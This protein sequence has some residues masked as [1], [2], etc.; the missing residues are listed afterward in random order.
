MP[1]GMTDPTFGD[2][3][4]LP[5]EQDLLLTALNSNAARPK[6]NGKQSFPRTTSN[7]NSLRLQQDGNN[8]PTFDGNISGAM[9]MYT[10][11]TQSTAGSA[12]RPGFGINESP[13]MDDDGEDGT[14]EWDVNG[15]PLI[16]DLPGASFSDEDAELHEKRK[17]HADEED[18]LSGRKRREGEEKVG[19]K[20]GR[21]LLTSEPTS[22]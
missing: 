10:S 14:Y 16:G 18:G 2:L 7:R 11:P 12:S 13:Y 9:G 17:T 5:A 3:L 15:D 20:P 4:L 19:K 8:V 21:K 1:G 22:V 6:A